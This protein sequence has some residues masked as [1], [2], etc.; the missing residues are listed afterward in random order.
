MRILSGFFAISTLLIAAPLS[1]ANAADMPL[2][3]PSP[4]PA[5]VASWTGFYVGGDIGG[6]WTSNTGT[7]TPLPSPAAFGANINTGGNGGASAIG[8]FHAG[9]NYQF[10]PTWVA[11]LEGDWSWSAAKGSFR[12]VWTALPPF[13]PG[14]VVG[15]FT[16]MSSKLDWVSSLRGRFGYLVTP[17]TLAYATGGV[18]WGKF[19]Y[20]A[21]NF[22]SATYATSA[23]FSTT[24]TGFT[25][26][27]GLEW[28]MTRNWLVRTE[29]LYYRFNNGPSVVAA[30]PG[31]PAF[32]SGYSWSGT[33]ISVVR[34]GASYK[35]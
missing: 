15:S 18:A 29:Y 35:F 19:D 26:G 30:A 20:A 22:N 14:P 6:A 23:A 25:V 3:A 8:G 24:Q 33:N 32:P 7:W 13:P 12:Q 27:G 10:A 5:P 21:N 16:N 17:N 28:A 1:I 31:F 34:A 4:P 9:Y 11:G 2:K